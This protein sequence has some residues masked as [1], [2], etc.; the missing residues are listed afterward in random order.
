M[1]LDQHLDA[2]LSEAKAGP[3]PLPST[4]LIA[5]V[6][7][8]AA[9]NVPTATVITEAVPG[10]GLMARLLSPIGGLGGAF[11]LAACAAFGVVAGAG[12]ADT[13]FEIPGLDSVLTTLTVDP[14]STSPYESL[15]L[16]MSES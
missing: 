10:K 1:T 2:L 14:D 16:L 6:L 9:E 3:V 11:A 8:D 5:R 7:A 12:Y 4:D 13:L 15:S